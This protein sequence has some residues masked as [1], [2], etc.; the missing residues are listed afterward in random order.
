MTT[1][2]TILRIGKGG[3]KGANAWYK[4]MILATAKG[5]G[6]SAK[7]RRRSGQWSVTVGSFTVEGEGN[8]EKGRGGEG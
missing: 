6:V 8:G 2:F 1:K 3:L 5:V 7:R 4:R